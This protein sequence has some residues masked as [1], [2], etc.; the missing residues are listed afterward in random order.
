MQT[1][2]DDATA[3]NV[4]PFPGAKP[5]QERPRSRERS[6]AKTKD[7]TAALRAKRYRQ[8]K[9]TNANRDGTAK[10]QEA[11][12][13][14]N[15][16]DASVAE[17]IRS[18]EKLCE[19]NGAVTVQDAPPLV[20]MTGAEV[21][22]R[23]HGRG[24]RTCAL[25]AA[26]GLAAVSGEFSI[27]GMTAIFVGAYWPVIGMGIAVEVG[28]LSAVAWLGHHD[29]GA[30]W[31]GLK[32]A[33]TILVLVLMGLNVVGVY[34]FLAKAHIGHQVEGET[35]IGG[36]MAEIQGRISVQEGV[37][38]SV[39]R[40]IAQIDKAVETATQRGRTSGAMQLAANQKRNRADLV[41]KHDQAATALANFKVE[42]AGIDGLAKVAEADLGPVRYLARLLGAGDQ[43]VLRWFILVVASLLDPAA[44][45]LLLAATRR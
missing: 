8:S 17:E 43:D 32:G 45:L 28:K 4:T 41:L 22:M 42:K 27:T 37:V 12:S 11:N 18:T 23:R 39:D 6:K 40:Q 34:G 19:I 25:V 44:V 13:Q 26:L 33:I 14:P 29:N 15:R 9:K 24:I 16:D 10:V 30:C 21:Q 5:G 36:R 1:T 38:A 2:D 20:P 35:A 31:M 7:P 3:D